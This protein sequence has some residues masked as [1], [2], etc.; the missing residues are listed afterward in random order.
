MRVSS[1]GGEVRCHR[2]FKPRERPRIDRRG[3]FFCT[4][5]SDLGL[6]HPGSS[7]P[8]PSVSS[9]LHGKGSLIGGSGLFLRPP[10]LSKK[11]P[12]P[13]PQPAAPSWPNQRARTPRGSAFFVLST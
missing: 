2:D 8:H 12:R 4:G 6:Y 3:L 1:K 7:R 13:E 10:D 11:I 5:L 9:S